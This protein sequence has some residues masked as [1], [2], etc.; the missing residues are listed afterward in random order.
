[1]SEVTDSIKN[2][3]RQ[4]GQVSNIAKFEMLGAFGVASVTDRN[5]FAGLLRKLGPAVLNKYGNISATAAVYHYQEMRDIAFKNTLGLELSN[6]ARRRRIG[7]QLTSSAK[8]TGSSYAPV[9]KEL[10]V[11]GKTGSM[12]GFALSKF[13]ELGYIGGQN[14]ALDYAL[15]EIAMANRDTV[16][17]NATLDN[18][19]EG[20]QRI[21]DPNACAFCLTIA[22]GGSKS[23]A[24]DYHNSCRCTVEPIFRGQPDLRPDY[25]DELEE[26]YNIGKEAAAEEG[27]SGAKAV[28]AA[29]RAETGA[30]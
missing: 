3:S 24:A 13:D 14:A 8:V 17:F 18:S 22:L 6:R 29:I 27:K 23:F 15:R 1:M 9:I 12:I 19:V 16:L 26:K 20:V 5:E 11:I 10:D 21:A 4:I 28:F 7:A 30:K 25:Y 2:N